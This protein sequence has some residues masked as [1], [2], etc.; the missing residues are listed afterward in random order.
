VENY[1]KSCLKNMP[2]QVSS[3]LFYQVKNQV[4]QLCKK[5]SKRKQNLIRVAPCANKAS[6]EFNKCNAIF[7]DKLLGISNADNKKKIPFLCW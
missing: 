5:D 3:V 2:K 6:N 1:T 4:K 7:I